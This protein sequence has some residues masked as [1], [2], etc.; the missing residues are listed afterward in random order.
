MH[1]II[2]CDFFYLQPFHAKTLFYNIWYASYHMQHMNH[3]H[4]LYID[5]MIWYN[6]STYSCWLSTRVLSFRISRFSLSSL[7]TTMLTT[8]VPW[9]FTSA[10]LCL[11]IKIFHCGLF[12]SKSTFI[13][14]Y[15]QCSHYSTVLSTVGA[16]DLNQCFVE[17]DGWGRREAR[18]LSLASI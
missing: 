18:E 13:W 14:S 16:R 5:Y 9:S 7:S 11:L 6:C 17:R 10:S 4:L 1:S 15:F 2:I 12:R 8:M 3:K